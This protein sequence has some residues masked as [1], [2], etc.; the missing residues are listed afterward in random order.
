NNVE[1]DPVA[2]ERDQQEQDQVAG[3][4]GDAEDVQRSP[5]KDNCEVRVRR[6]NRRTDGPSRQAD[7]KDAGGPEECGVPYTPQRK[8]SHDRDCENQRP[9]MGEDERK[10]HREYQ[11]N[12]P[13]AASVVADGKRRP[14]QGMRHPH[15]GWEAE[16]QRAKT[17]SR[18]TGVA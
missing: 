8:R 17:S 12:A 18:E 10:R 14:E 5:A 2:R 13:I 15:F 1:R 6:E 3:E 7:K 4:D 9:P 11:R 16:D